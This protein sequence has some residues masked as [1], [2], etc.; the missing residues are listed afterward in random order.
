MVRRKRKRKRKKSRIEREKQWYCSHSLLHRGNLRG[1]AVELTL[2]LLGDLPSTDNRERREREKVKTNE[3]H[4]LTEI[5][6]VN[7]EIK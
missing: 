4:I 1:N 2:T 5:Q 6:F 7:L 3:I